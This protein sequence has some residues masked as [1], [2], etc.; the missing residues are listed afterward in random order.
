[1]LL[2]TVVTEIQSWV[3]MIH[4]IVDMLLFPCLAVTININGTKRVLLRCLCRTSD[5]ALQNLVAVTKREMVSTFA[6]VL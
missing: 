2:N 3:A 6:I 1:M 5:L 4:M